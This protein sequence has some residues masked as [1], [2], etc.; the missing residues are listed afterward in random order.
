LCFSYFILI[1]SYKFG[2]CIKNFS[3]VWH[4]K[5]YLKIFCLNGLF[6]RQTINVRISNRHHF[7]EH[8]NTAIKFYA[9][10]NKNRIPKGILFLKQKVEN[11]SLRLKKKNDTHPPWRHLYITN[12]FQLMQHISDK[13]IYSPNARRILLKELLMWNNN[14][15]SYIGTS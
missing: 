4:I 11:D 12:F 8:I 2:F 13:D 1:N 3:S 10:Q 15:S 6:L 9:T 7:N 5:S 14:K